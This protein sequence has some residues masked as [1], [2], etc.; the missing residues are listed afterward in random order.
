MKDLTAERLRELLHYDPET[1]AFT[2]IVRT[3]NVIK[4]GDF[5]G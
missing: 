1:G 5:A 3:S 2:R 4:V